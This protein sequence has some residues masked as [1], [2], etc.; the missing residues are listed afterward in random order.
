VASNWGITPK[1]SIALACAKWGSDEVV[2]ASRALLRGEEI[3]PEILLAL[4]GPGARKFLDGA[5]HPDGYWVRVWGAR[6]LLWKWHPSAIG[7]IEIALEDDSW[8]VREMALG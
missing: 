7:E 6:A 3:S 2:N 5:H 8:R 1:Q 4:G